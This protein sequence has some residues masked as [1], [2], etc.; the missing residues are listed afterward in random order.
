MTRISRINTEGNEGNEEGG[1]F[2][3]LRSLGFLLFKDE[4]QS[5]G[6]E[7]RKPRNT[8][9]ETGYERI[10]LKN[11]FVCFVYFVVKPSYFSFKPQRRSHRDRNA[12]I[13]P[14]N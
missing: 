7:V 14:D 1:L 12:V 6:F 8:P 4:V 5:S 9:K 11:L 2:R 3:I 10:A 13:P